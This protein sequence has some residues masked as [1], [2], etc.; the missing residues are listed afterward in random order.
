MIL[1]KNCFTDKAISFEFSK[2]LIKAVPIIA[3][4]EYFDADS[5]VSLSL[6]PNPTKTGFFKFISCKRS[7]YCSTALKSLSL[8]VVA[9]ELTA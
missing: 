3:P 7:R 6:I 9:D 2:A 8:P 4:F 5:N 1:L